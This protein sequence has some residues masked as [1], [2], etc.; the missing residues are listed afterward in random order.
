MALEN[1]KYRRIAFRE[2][3]QYQFAPQTDLGDSPISRFGGFLSCDL[4]AGGA[5]FRANDF[6]PLDAE[7]SLDIP[8]YGGD[9]VLSLDGKVVWIQKLPHA[10]H[11]FFGLCFIET[12]QNSQDRKALREFISRYADS[13]DLQESA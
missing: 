2:P 6:I 11:Y 7:L 3:V 8:I 10:E 13:A 1:R 5:R 12:P 4:S 9:E